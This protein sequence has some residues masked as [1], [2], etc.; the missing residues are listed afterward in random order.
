MSKL[1]A[2]VPQADVQ[3]LF[4]APAP[5]LVSD[6]GECNWG[7]GGITVD[8]FANDADKSLYGGGAVS[9]ATAAHLSGVGDIAQWTQPVPGHTVP[10]LI[11]HKGTTSIA[12]SPS[13][14]VDQTSIAYTGSA[15]FFN[16]SHAEALK[17]AIGRGSDLQ[18][19][20]LG[21]GLLIPGHGRRSGKTVGRA[22]RARRVGAWETFLLARVCG[23]CARTSSLPGGSE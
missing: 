5:P 20:L 3:K 19:H 15:P 17:Y 21:H 6:P 9:V 7:N 14:N 1:C 4:K 12:V 16:V 13:L 22:G 2:A 10:F 11:A 18:R 23:R 8:I